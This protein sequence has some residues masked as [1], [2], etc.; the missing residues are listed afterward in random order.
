MSFP[1]TKGEKTTSCEITR[2]PRTSKGCYTCYPLNI[3][4]GSVDARRMLTEITRIM[5]F[6]VFSDKL[7]T[8][9]DVI[10][11][12]D[13]RKTPSVLRFLDN[14]FHGIEAI[15][16]VEKLEDITWQTGKMFA[17]LDGAKCVT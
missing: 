13:S 14:V 5:D 6:V 11:C 9:V 2:R 17:D 10:A 12:F 4:V 15:P 16:S 8:S 7:S 3:F 1:K